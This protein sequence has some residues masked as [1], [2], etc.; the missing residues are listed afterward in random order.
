MITTQ[1]QYYGARRVLPCFDEPAFKASIRL[2]LTG[3]KGWNFISNTYPEGK[4]E[5]FGALEEKI[6]FAPTIK[7]SIYLFAFSINMLSKTQVIEL[8]GTKS[9]YFS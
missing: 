9:K 7:M 6:C 8:T 5:N 2:C 4:R 3:P 1:N